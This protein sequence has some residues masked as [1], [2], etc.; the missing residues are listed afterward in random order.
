MRASSTVSFSALSRFRFLE[1]LFTCS[2]QSKLLL[3][4]F[5]CQNPHCLLQTPLYWMIFIW[6]LERTPNIDNK[7]NITWKPV[8]YRRVSRSSHWLYSIKLFLSRSSFCQKLSR[9]WVMRSFMDTPDG[10]SPSIGIYLNA[11]VNTFYYC[12]F[13][14]CTFKVCR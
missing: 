4:Y 9:K 3:V 8:G 7:H 12:W 10:N 14:S 2:L 13:P 5:F 6:I 11:K 1:F